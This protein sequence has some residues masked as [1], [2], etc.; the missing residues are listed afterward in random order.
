M[1]CEDG[2]EAKFTRCFLMLANGVATVRTAD[3]F[4]VNLAVEQVRM[5]A[6]EQ[7]V[8]PETVFVEV[9]ADDGAVG[10]G[11]SSTIGTGGTPHFLMRAIA[12]ETSGL[13]IAWDRDAVDDRRAA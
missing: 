6:V 9:T 3:A 8:S 5:D 7:F 2:D 13:A 12:P 10:L 11:Y 1:I 4:P